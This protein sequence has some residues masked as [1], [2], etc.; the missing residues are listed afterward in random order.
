MFTR[1]VSTIA[2][3]FNHN[4]HQPQH[5]HPA[6]THIS[7][8]IYYATTANLSS[9]ATSASPSGKPITMGPNMVRFYLILFIS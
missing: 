6:C 4:Q 5:H 2:S 9:S 1:R 3:H 7:N 8:S